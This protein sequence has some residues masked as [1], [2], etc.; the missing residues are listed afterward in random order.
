MTLS[1]VIIIR[2]ESQTKDEKKTFI[3]KRTLTS[4]TLFNKR[5][6]EK[7]LLEL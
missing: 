1:R 3:T 4:S 5:F 7:I 2:N 6:C